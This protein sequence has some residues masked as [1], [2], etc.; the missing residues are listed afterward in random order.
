MSEQMRMKFMR[1]AIKR[2]RI[3]AKNQPRAVTELFIM[4]AS[5]FIQLLAAQNW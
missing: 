4:P 2:T 5:R 3:P 1:R